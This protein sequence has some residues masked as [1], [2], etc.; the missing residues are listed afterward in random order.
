MHGMLESQVRTPRDKP[1]VFLLAFVAT[2]FVRTLSPSLSLS[3]HWNQQKQ[4]HVI[5]AYH[6]TAKT[7]L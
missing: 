1:C 4:S 6:G 2:P 5:V 7:S 3:Q